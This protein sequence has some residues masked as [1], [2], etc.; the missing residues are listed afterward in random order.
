MSG[1]KRCWPCEAYE[2]IV[3]G[4]GEE[5]SI[6]LSRAVDHEISLRS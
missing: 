6:L 2:D 4:R 5:G 1:V 3:L